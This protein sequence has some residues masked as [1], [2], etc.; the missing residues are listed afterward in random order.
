[1]KNQSSM[2][3]TALKFVLLIGVMSFFADFTYEGSRSTIGP[4][5][6]LLEVPVAVQSSQSPCEG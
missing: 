1:M 5:L 6:G 2:K 3:A 4:Y